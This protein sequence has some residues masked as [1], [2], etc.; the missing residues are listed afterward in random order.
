MKIQNFAIA[1]ICVLP[2]SCAKWGNSDNKR[3]MQQAEYLMEHQPDSALLLLDAVNTS[4]FNYARRAEYTLLRFQAKDKAEMDI[5]ADTEIFQA[6]EYFTNG[7]EREKAAWA[8]F[9]AGMVQQMQGEEAKALEYYLKAND[10]AS[11]AS[12]DHLLRGRIQCKIGDIKYTLGLY[13]NALSHFELANEFFSAAE[14]RKSEIEAMI[15]IGICYL[16]LNKNDSAFS[17]FNRAEK[18]ATSAKD[19]DMLL[20][21]VQNMGVAFEVA[22][23]YS[24]AADRYLTALTWADHKDSAQL[25]LNLADVYLNTGRIDNAFVFGKKALATMDSTADNSMR[26]TAYRIMLQIEAHRGNGDKVIEYFS[27]HVE[28]LD[29]IYEK[30][31]KESL[32]EVQKKFDFEKAQAEYAIEK[33]N[34]AIGI[35][36]AVIVAL[37]FMFWSF[38]QRKRKKRHESTIAQLMLQLDELRETEQELQKLKDKE[39]NRQNP[40]KSKY[41]KQTK[42]FFMQYFRLLD[43]I[44]RECKHVP[45]EQ[46]ALE[47]DK[48]KRVVFGSS[49]YNF[50]TATEKMIPEG[51]I[52]T[53][54]KICP[55]LDNTELK[56]CCLTCLNAD[57]EIIS[58]A[59]DL[60]DTS[61]YSANSRIRK[62]LGMRGEKDIKVF[63]EK[64]LSDQGFFL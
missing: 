20:A 33:R 31:E 48:L 10:F 17:F 39:I 53:I 26:I 14:H 8:C 32:L 30:R 5:T 44:A 50:W 41:A 60:K 15:D 42:M 11:H 2:V 23:N 43:K 47:I 52:D 18:L 4:S 28:C 9:F 45:P 46:K 29:E 59:L 56:I 40:E 19:T 64:K 61:V 27:K 25:L 21:V 35:L 7:K 24:M 3:L 6:L 34:L 49:D 54:K 38:N 57:N 16:I 36:S 22:G 1:L 63:L 13:E 55:E 12:D 62:K 37:G 58:L 51:I